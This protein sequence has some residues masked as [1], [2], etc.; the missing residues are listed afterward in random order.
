MTPNPKQK[1]IGLLACLI[2]ILLVDLYWIYINFWWHWF[3]GVGFV[4]IGWLIGKAMDCYF[5][6]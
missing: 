1:I 4:A 6:H 2:I 3:F 5:T